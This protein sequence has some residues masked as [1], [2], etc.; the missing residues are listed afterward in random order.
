MEAPLVVPASSP[1]NFV[2]VIT[3]S[4]RLTGHLNPTCIPPSTSD[5]ERLDASEGHAQDNA[6]SAA[7][8]SDVVP[9][10]SSVFVQST[11]MTIT[12]GVGATCVCGGG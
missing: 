5:D 4:M 3:P 10:W 9:L 12:T 7:A 6:A 11:M 1:S 2:I 8:V